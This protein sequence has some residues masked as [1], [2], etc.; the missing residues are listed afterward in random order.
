MGKRQI[1]ITLD[2]RYRG[3]TFNVRDKTLFKPLLKILEGLITD[4]LSN[5]FKRKLF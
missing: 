3:E 2:L 4:I 5:G 1:I